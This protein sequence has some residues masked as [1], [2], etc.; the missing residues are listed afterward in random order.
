MPVSIIID[1]K[2]VTVIK[3]VYM[4]YVPVKKGI[5]SSYVTVINGQHVSCASLYIDF[6]EIFDRCL[7]FGY[8]ILCGRLQSAYNTCDCYVTMLISMCQFTYTE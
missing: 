1:N 6:Y 7:R 8:D 3:M 4:P 2:L 5:S